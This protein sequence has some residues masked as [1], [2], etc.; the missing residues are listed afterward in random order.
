MVVFNQLYYGIN[1]SAKLS[2]RLVF[3]SIHMMSV[4]LRNHL[5]KV[6]VS[7]FYSETPP[8]RTVMWTGNRPDRR[9]VRI[10]G[11]DEQE[12]WGLGGLLT[13]SVDE[14]SG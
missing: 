12:L 11:V 13:R 1:V 7:L 5:K 9:G 2:V 10:R 14:V 3:P 6:N 4:F 8:I